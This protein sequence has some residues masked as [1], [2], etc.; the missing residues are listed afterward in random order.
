MIKGIN[1]NITPDEQADAILNDLGIN[2]DVINTKNSKKS[3]SE[4]FLSEEQ[5]RN[6]SERISQA[7][8][9]CLQFALYLVCIILVIVAHKLEVAMQE[10]TS[11][12]EFWTMLGLGQWL[13][14]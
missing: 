1:K 5:F 12:E 7:Y 2:P 8:S 11:A 4:Y 13:N 9:K 10:A 6:L 3:F 14:K